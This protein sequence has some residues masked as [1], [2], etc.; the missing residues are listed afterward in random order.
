MW[1]WASS[2]LIKDHSLSVVGGRRSKD[3]LGVVG[4]TDHRVVGMAGM[5]KGREEGVVEGRAKRLVE[6]RVARWQVHS[7]IQGR[8]SD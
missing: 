1:S 4:A 7:G 3:Q 8:H 2:H 6:C 5:V